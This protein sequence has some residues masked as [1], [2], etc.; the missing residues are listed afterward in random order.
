[1]G[2]AGTHVQT[3]VDDAFS[4]YREL[5]RGEED[6]ARYFLVAVPSDDKGGNDAKVE[7]TLFKKYLLENHKTFNSL[8]FPEK[9]ALLGLIN[10][11]QKEEGKFA[12]DGFPNKL[13][14]LLHG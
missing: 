13:G 5:K 6:T 7:K 14:L 4:W 10:Q 3:W 1:M 12:I 9:E 11:F 2:Q 8:W